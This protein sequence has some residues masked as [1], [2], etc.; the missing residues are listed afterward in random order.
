MKTRE[1]A[2]KLTPE[3]LA[4]TPLEKWETL[5]LHGLLGTDEPWIEDMRETLRALSAPP[6]DGAAQEAVEA[7]KV[8]DS[9]QPYATTGKVVAQ[10]NNLAEALRS[11]LARLK[12]PA[13]KGWEE[14][15]DELRRIVACDDE[16]TTQHGGLADCTDNE[17]EPYQS[18][19]LANCLF[20]ARHILAAYQGSKL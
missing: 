14:G 9:Y 17:G 2:M 19:E 20:R 12:A 10:A 15:I 6:A 8:W 4:M 13:S 5:A 11:A 7:L 18:Q 3:Y 1:T 16:A